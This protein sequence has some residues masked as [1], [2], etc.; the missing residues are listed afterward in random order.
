MAYMGSKE[1]WSYWNSVHWSSASCS[2]RFVDDWEFEM[3]VPRS[4]M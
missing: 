4:G 3:R 1:R 2:A